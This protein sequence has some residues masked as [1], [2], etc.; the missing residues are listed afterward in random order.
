MFHVSEICNLLLLILF[1][2]K[3]HRVCNICFSEK[4][5]VCVRSLLVHNYGK[6][7]LDKLLLIVMSLKHDSIFQK[8]TKVSKFRKFLYQFC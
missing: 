2:Q 1:T 5:F 3:N 8:L 4:L 6:K 7:L